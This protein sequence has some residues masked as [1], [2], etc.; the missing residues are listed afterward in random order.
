[1]PEE[2]SEVQESQKSAFKTKPNSIAS[3]SQGESHR[4]KRKVPE[5]L[6]FFLMQEWPNDS[7]MT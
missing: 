5:V 4:F 3:G 1:M 7:R 2:S 6:Q